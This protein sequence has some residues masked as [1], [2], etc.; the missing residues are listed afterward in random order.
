MP[1]VSWLNHYTSSSGGLEIGLKSFKELHIAVHHLQVPTTEYVAFWLTHSLLV[2]STLNPLD[3]LP[4]NFLS[5]DNFLPLFI[6]FKFVPCSTSGTTI[7]PYC[8]APVLYS[9]PSKSLGIRIEKK[10]K[11]SLFCFM[12]FSPKH[13]QIC[14]PPLIPI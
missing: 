9:P 12:P 2:P 7:N 14:L 6:L 1:L 10:K 8:L 4:D 5:L 11:S 3:F 13:A